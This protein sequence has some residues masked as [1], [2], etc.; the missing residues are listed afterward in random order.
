MDLVFNYHETLDV[1][2]R[3]EQGAFFT[4]KVWVDQVHKLIED[5]VGRNWREFATVW[6][7]AC[8]AGALTFGH[9]IK[10]LYCSGIEEPELN[11]V[12]ETQPEATVFNFDFL[13]DNTEDL[14]EDLRDTLK[15]SRRKFVVVVNPP[16]GKT[17]SGAR[18]LDEYAS[19]GRSRQEMCFLFLARCAEIASQYQG[20]FHIVSISKNFYNQTSQAFLDYMGERLTNTGGF[21]FNSKEFPTI[22]AQWPVLV[23]HWVNK[24]PHPLLGLDPVHATYSVLERA[25]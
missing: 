7:M 6:D 10:S 9:E 1:K 5:R 25:S 2:Q 8:G 12:R 24:E 20:E 22:T 23:T 17:P 14:P 16:Y 3:K 19:L 21:V 11:I 4:P 13:N 15:S 18:L